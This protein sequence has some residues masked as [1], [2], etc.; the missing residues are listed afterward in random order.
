MVLTIWN[1]R[2]SVQEGRMW[3]LKVFGLSILWS[4]AYFLYFLRLGKEW[5]RC[6]LD[7]LSTCLQTPIP[8]GQGVSVHCYH[9]NRIVYPHTRHRS[10]WTKRDILL[11]CHDSHA[12]ID[13]WGF[14]SW[15]WDKTVDSE[16]ASTVCSRITSGKWLGAHIPVPSLA[17]GHLWI[18]LSDDF[19]TLK[20]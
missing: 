8:L 6:T 17:T 7:V 11:G 9:D 16:P 4:M 1:I 20:P 5:L 10:R 12:N 14:D 3:K 13:D 2:F 15:T 19:E 18:S